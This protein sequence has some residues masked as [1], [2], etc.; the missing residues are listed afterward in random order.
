MKL[1]Y[2]HHHFSL[3]LYTT[4]GMS[5]GYSRLKFSLPKADDRNFLAGKALEF[6]RQA[7][8]NTTAYNIGSTLSFPPVKDLT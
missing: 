8:K 7:P 3:L 5:E 4:L 1:T 6:L 2:L